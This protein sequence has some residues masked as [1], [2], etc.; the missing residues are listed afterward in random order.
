MAD[1]ILLLMNPPI[2]PA[3]S[4]DDLETLLY[5]ERTRRLEAEAR[6]E[7]E[8]SAARDYMLT[9]RQATSETTPYSGLVSMNRAAA[10]LR[11]LWGM[12]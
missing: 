7:A 11:K 8:R 5:L 3:T 6:L 4:W 1:S 2:P 12:A 9:V 10:T